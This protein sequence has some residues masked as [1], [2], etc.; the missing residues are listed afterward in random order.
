MRYKICLALFILIVFICGATSSY[1]GWLIYSKPE[2]KGKVIDSETKEPIEGAVVVAMYSKRT[3]GGPGGAYSSIIKVKEQ[4][5]D[6]K[7]EFKFSSYTT[8][9]QP[10]STES[11]V[12]F[13]V[14]KPGYGSFPGYHKVLSGI[15]PKDQE[16]Y[17]S[18]ETGSMGELDMWVKTEKH[19]DLVRFKVAFGIVE[20]PKLKT[21]EERRKVSVGP[22]GERSDWKNQK[23]FIK[24]IRQEWEYLTGKPAGDLYKIK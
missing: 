20:L 7:G 23:Q 21:K 6:K 1:A 18:K 10:L 22:E 8:L 5:T 19:P 24:L 16:T 13:I 15:K 2:L 3:I 14:F 9:I 4:L 12:T 17:F 11:L